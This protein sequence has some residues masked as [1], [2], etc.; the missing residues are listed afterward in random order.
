MDP[1]HL[2]LLDLPLVQGKALEKLHK[3]DVLGGGGGSDRGSAAHSHRA[4][5]DDGQQHP[6]GH[7]LFEV[8]AEAAERPLRKRGLGHCREDLKDLLLV[9]PGRVLLQEG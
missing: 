1:T 6:S 7:G 2:A 3:V 4:R 9:A 8:F 5:D